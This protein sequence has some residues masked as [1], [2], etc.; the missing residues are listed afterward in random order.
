MKLKRAI[1]LGYYLKQLDRGKFL[2]FLKHT[3]KYTGKSTFEIISDTLKSVFIYNI[4]PL[5]YFQFH[6]YNLSQEERE[7]WAGTGHMYEYQLKMNPRDKRDILENKTLFY[8]H[9]GDFLIHKVADI[10]DIK[11]KNGLAKSL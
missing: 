2:L 7:A 6:F 10:E 4:S 1:Y 9:Y 3:K 11:H 5:E 8:K